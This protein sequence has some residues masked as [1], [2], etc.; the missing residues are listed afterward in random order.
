[1]D[2]ELYRYTHCVTYYRNYN[3]LWITIIIY[4]YKYSRQWVTVCSVMISSGT[5]LYR[6]LHNIKFLS[7]IISDLRKRLLVSLL[8]IT[9]RRWCVKLRHT[10]CRL[11]YSQVPC[12]RVIKLLLIRLYY[13]YW[14][15]LE[16][17]VFT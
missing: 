5:I 4:W 17:V 3:I 11:H 2:L 9:C 14:S 12:C 7:L 16:C 10:P 13:R 15:C 1:M 8:K 6:Y